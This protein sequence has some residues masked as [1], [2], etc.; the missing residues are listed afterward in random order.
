MLEVDCMHVFKLVLRTKGDHILQL[1]VVLS[2]GEV[3]LVLRVLLDK[4]LP[5]WLS[6]LDVSILCFRAFL[7][8]LA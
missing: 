8:L 7:V 3:N 2:L 4:N 6:V 1:L 5:F